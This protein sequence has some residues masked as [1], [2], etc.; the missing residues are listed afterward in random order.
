M[1]A[2]VISANVLLVVLARDVLQSGPH[3]Y[4]YLNA[5]WAV[6]AVAGGFLVA[7]LVRRFPAMTVLL[8]ALVV[9]SV[10]HALFPYVGLLAVAVAMNALFGACRALGGVLTQTAIMATVPRRL[11]GRTQSAFGV[12]STLLQVMMSF[13]LGWLAQHANLPVAFVM[14]AM[15]YGGA[16][17]AAW[18]AK[19]LS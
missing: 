17:V 1:M 12:I 19:A 10:G 14:L 7:P 11:M 8:V 6:G 2:G 18:R 3:G 9:T 15:M 16:A 5:G 13:S 4:G